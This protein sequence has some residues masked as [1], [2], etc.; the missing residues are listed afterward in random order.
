[1]SAA[2]FLDSNVVIYAFDAAGGEK[3][4]IASAILDAALRQGSAIISFQV[5]QETL[6]VIGRKFRRVA[7]PE[8]CRAALKQVLVPLWRIHPSAT[9]YARGLGIQERYGLGFYDSLILAAAME[10]GCTRLL[11]EDLQHGQRIEGLRIENPFVG[12]QG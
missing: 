7:S 3:S 1:M 4:A 5:V 6:N 8:D 2:D 11:S 10:G 9:L 12:T